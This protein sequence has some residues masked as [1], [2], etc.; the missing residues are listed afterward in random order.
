MA[1]PTFKPTPSQRK[2]V[3]ISAGAGTAHDSIATALGIARG[4]LELHF[5]KELTEG[6]AKRRQAVVEAMYKAA[7]ESGNVTAMKAYLGL[8]V[9][10][11]APAGDQGKKAQANEAAKTAQHGTAWADLLPNTVQ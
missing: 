10:P 1:R 3:A 5:A 4:T 7:V 8:T 9:A 2:A 11:T 6:A